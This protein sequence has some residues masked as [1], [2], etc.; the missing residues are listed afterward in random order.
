M[1]SKRRRNAIVFLLFRFATHY[2]IPLR[3]FPAKRVDFAFPEAIA[4]F[5]RIGY[6]GHR[7]LY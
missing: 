1:A 3:G 7:K 5:P 2:T 4:I 6:N